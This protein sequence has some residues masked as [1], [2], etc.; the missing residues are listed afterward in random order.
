MSRNLTFGIDVEIID[1]FFA[2]IFIF[3]FLSQSIKSFQI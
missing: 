3:L 2:D 1:E